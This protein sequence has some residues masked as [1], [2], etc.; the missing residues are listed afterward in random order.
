MHWVLSGAGNK[1]ANKAVQST[2]FWTLCSSRGNNLITNLQRTQAT[3]IRDLQ[4]LYLW[5]IT[6]FWFGVRSPWRYI[7]ERD[8]GLAFWRVSRN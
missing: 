5:Y 2:L 4:K 6:Y 7:R 3:T 1:V 8:T